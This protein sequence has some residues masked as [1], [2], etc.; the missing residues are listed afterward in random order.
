MPRPSKGFTLTELLVVIAII[1]VLG[2]LAYPNFRDTIQRNRL[3]AATNEA[4]AGLSFARMEAIR[5]TTAAWLCP[6]SDGSTCGSDWSAGM[7]VQTDTNR[8]RV[9]DASVRYIQ[10]SPQTRTTIAGF[11]GT[12]NRIQFDGRG[13]LESAAAAPG[14][15]A[16][17]RTIT[18][19][20][21]P[22]PAGKPMS[23]RL[24]L[25]SSGQVKMQSEDCP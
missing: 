4:L 8:D 2:T 5:T 16:Q 12:S 15:V 18:I 19:Q 13:R 14:G 9:P 17:V 10:P 20:A 1:A 6:S 7:L 22:C 25:N 3:V 11:A 23:R 24:T 21:D